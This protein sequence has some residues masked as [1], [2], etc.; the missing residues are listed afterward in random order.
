MYDADQ[1]QFPEP[2]PSQGGLKKPRDLSK[3]TQT[4]HANVERAADREYTQPQIIQTMA[5]GIE[6]PNP[7]SEN[8]NSRILRMN[9]IDHHNMRRAIVADMESMQPVTLL[10][11]EPIPESQP[12]PAV[13]VSSTKKKKADQLARKRARSG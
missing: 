11:R 13:K 8:P 10:P 4:V 3:Y 1:V 12:A 2:H 6:Y 9:S 5:H 7:N